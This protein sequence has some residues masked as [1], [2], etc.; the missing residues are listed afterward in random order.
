M[1]NPAPIAIFTYKRKNYLEILINS[2]KKNN[3]SNQSIIYIFSDHWKNNSEKKNVLEVRRY[4]SKLSGFKKIIIISRKKN[5]GLSKNIINGINFVLK[6]N[7]KVIVLEEDLELSKYFLSFINSGLKIYKNNLNV[8]SI[9]GYFYPIDLEKKFS[10]TFF[11]KGA[12]CWGWGTWKRS[13]LKLNL[14][15]KY[16]LKQLKKKKLEME[17]NFNNSYNYMLMLENQIRR[18]N[19]SW[20]ILWNAS[21]FLENMYTLYPKMSLVKNNGTKDG[22]HS[23]FD[24]LNLGNSL[25]QLKFKPLLKIKVE[26]SLLVRKKIEFFFKKNYLFRFKEFIKKFFDL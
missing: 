15:G 13:W 14:N 12:D 8:A 4:I 6:N 25:L 23:K 16:L 3:L 10:D 17:F 5:F 2:L 7:N 24:F 22:K 1:K 18:K 9:H 11:I 26:E 19:D 21:M 20:A